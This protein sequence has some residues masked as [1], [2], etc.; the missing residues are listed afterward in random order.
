V[1]SSA[2]GRR[3]QS[4]LTDDGNNPWWRQMPQ[5][6]RPMPRSCKVRSQSFKALGGGWASQA[7]RFRSIENSAS[8]PRHFATAKWR[9]LTT[10]YRHMSR[11]GRPGAKLRIGAECHWATVGRCYVH[12]SGVDRAREPVSNGANPT[13]LIPVYAA[14]HSAEKEMRLIAGARSRQQSA[15]AAPGS[16]S[17]GYMQALRDVLVIVLKRKKCP[18]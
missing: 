5:W 1:I 17:S 8:R 10:Y 12:G 6:P 7:L 2:P 3:E 18:H 14:K 15:Q 4:R 9:V 13:G 16:S 11:A